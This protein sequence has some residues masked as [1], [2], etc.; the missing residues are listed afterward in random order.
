MTLLDRYDPA[1]DP[2]YSYL[3]AQLAYAV[4]VDQRTSDYLLAL[5]GQG[6]HEH[7]RIADAAQVDVLGRHL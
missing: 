7:R 3:P 6:L 1:A 2:H 4:L 5:F